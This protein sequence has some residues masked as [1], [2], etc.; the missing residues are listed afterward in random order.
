MTLAG[1]SIIT[2]KNWAIIPATAQNFQ[3]TS[4]GLS[5]L[6]IGDWN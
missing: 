1:S 2:I 5:D 6:F 3:K 4:F